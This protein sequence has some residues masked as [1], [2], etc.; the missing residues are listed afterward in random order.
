[1]GRAP[2]V[3][4]RGARSGPRAG[5][6]RPRDAVRPLP[7]GVL[8]EETLEVSDAALSAARRAALA[9]P[10][11]RAAYLA[12]YARVHSPA[13]VLRERVRVGD[14]RADRVELAAR[15]A[16]PVAREVHP[17]VQLVDWTSWRERREFLRPLMESDRC[18]VVAW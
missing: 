10:A 17:R 11:E 14:L 6:R 15:L 8:A 1:G 5:A 2:A 18:L 9:D 3:R 13:D 7:L 12:R 4:P 16:H